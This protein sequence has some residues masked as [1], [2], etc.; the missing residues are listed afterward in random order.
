VGLAR[1]PLVAH[2]VATRHPHGKP[3]SPLKINSHSCAFQFFF[4]NLYIYKI[5]TMVNWVELS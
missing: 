2:G 1:E 3:P 4:I 5:L